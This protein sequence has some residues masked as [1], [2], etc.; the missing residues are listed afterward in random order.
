LA[1]CAA[2]SSFP[3]NWEPW[4]LTVATAANGNTYLYATDENSLYGGVQQCLL[5]S[6]GSTSSCSQTASG[7]AISGG[8]VHLGALR[9]SYVVEVCNYNSDASISGC[10]STGSGFSN[11]SF[12]TI[13]DG[14]V[15][16]VNE[17]ADTVGVC[18]V[19]TNG[20]LTSC[21]TSPLP[22]GTYDAK[23]VVFNGSQAYV[24]DKEA[25]ASAPRRDWRSTQSLACA[26]ETRRSRPPLEAPEGLTEGQMPGKWGASQAPRGE[27]YVRGHRPDSAQ[28]G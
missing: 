2:Y 28:L 16:V 8:H 26:H 7:I 17:S 19:G 4:A 11:P 12:I 15:Y 23:S 10:S 13:N 22:A 25:T 9:G 24:D 5:A 18:T 20:A 27:D 6:N 21:P 1:S 14:Y 3:A